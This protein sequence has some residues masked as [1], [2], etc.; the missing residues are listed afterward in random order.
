VQQTFQDGKSHSQEGVVT[1]LSGK[2]INVLTTT[3]PIRDE[4]GRIVSVMEMSANITQLRELESQLTSLG[5]MIGSVSHGLRGLV[6]G[7]AGGIYFLKTGL[8]KDNPKRLAQGMDTVQRNFERIRS[9]V[10]DILYYA[11]E[12]EPNFE[13][14]SADQVVDEVIDLVR[15]RAGEN[16]IEITTEGTGK[17]V[18]LEADPQAV[19]S[20]L[21]NLVDNSI[22]A[23]RLDKKKSEHRV[24]LAVVD[25]PGTVLFEIEDN[26]IGMDRESRE[27]AFTL[28]FS[29]KGTEGTGLG[30]FIANRIAGAHG[31]SIALRSEPGDGAKFTVTLPKARNEEEA[32]HG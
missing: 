22:D 5:L 16:G 26:G 2:T 20:M 19:R 27:K 12:R 8:A 24:R 29:S 6:N 9:M 31:G 3:A 23:C 18:T 14:V 17:G 1:S 32:A 25:G 30:L 4:E 28:F 15:T 21:V 7:L 10:S 13:T 11:K